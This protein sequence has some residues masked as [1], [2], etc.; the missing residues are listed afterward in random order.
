MASWVVSSKNVFPKES[1]VTVEVNGLV[2]E[3]VCATFVDYLFVVITQ[4]NKFGT[5]LR[6]DSVPKADGGYLF[7]VSTMLGKRDDPLLMIYA[8]QIAERLSPFTQ[9]PLVLSISLL[10][11][12]RSPAH[13]EAIVNK[14]LE[15]I[16]VV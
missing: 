4:I 9:R 11:E 12:G 2:T 8:R 15:T 5:V 10:D 6:A 3:I 16:V 14:V 7:S 1:L 13:F